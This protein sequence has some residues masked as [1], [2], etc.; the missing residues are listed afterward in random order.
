MNVSLIHP[1]IIIFIKISSFIFALSEMFRLKS[2]QNTDRKE[3]SHCK[4]SFW[5]SVRNTEADCLNLFSTIWLHGLLV[6]VCQL[7]S[8]CLFSRSDSLVPQHSLSLWQ[9]MTHTHIYATNVGGGGRWISVDHTAGSE[10]SEGWS[11]TM[12]LRIRLS[13]DG[14]YCKEAK[15]SKRRV[16][17]MGLA[18]YLGRK[19]GRMSLFF[20]RLSKVMRRPGRLEVGPLWR[21]SGEFRLLKFYM[22]TSSLHI[23]TNFCS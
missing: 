19:L 2:S 20:C 1:N 23:S 17:L 21:K 15:T 22:T 16:G 6:C 12:I 4:S 14:K 8:S 7:P 5:T 10:T 13:V 9:L 3:V 11:W 18:E